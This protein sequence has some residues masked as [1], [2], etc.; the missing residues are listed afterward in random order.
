M[1]GVPGSPKPSGSNSFSLLH[2]SK[3]AFKHCRR[4]SYV[5][6]CNPL[7]PCM[8]PSTPQCEHSPPVSKAALYPHHV[9]SFSFSRTFSAL[10]RLL[11]SRLSFPCFLPLPAGIKASSSTF[12]IRQFAS[13][14]PYFPSLLLTMFWFYY[15]CMQAAKHAWN[16][17][18]WHADNMG[19][20]TGT[21]QM[22]AVW[23]GHA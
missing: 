21:G 14:L 2:P 19:Q 23:D 7:L 17:W 6:Y 5:R 1:C 16:L 22:C 20:K 11:D 13:C 4:L 9:I 18:V 15:F 12:K 10:L 8:Q 3:P